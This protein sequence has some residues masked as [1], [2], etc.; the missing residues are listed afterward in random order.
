VIG[1][2]PYVSVDATKVDVLAL[3]TL[4]GN[5]RGTAYWHAQVPLPR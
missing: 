4:R 5:S 1:G 3:V 2:P